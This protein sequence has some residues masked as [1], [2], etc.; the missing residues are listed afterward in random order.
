MK[1]AFTMIELIFV[2][3]IIGI[4]SI[5]IIPNYNTNSLQ[6]AAVQ[7]VTHLRYTQ[8]LAIVN[9]KYNSTDSKWYKERWQLVFS[10]STY[11]GGS[12][13]WA[14]TIFSDTAGNHTGDASESEIAHNPQ[15]PIQLM[16]GGY[17]DPQSI[18]IRDNGFKGMKKL[19][20]GKSYGIIGDNT[21]LKAVKLHGGCN[22]NRIVFDYLGRPLKGNLS[23]MSKPYQAK[24]KRL[25]SKDCIITLSSNNKSIDI[26]I[27]SETGYIRINY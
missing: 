27:S 7:L 20:I 25:I 18:D 23:T 21:D 13:I 17:G 6:D 2:L 3:I 8:H 11:T 4:L 10:S 26:V 1:K 24:S 16:T 12:D 14:Y 19:N 22:Y 9:D 15:N 5:V